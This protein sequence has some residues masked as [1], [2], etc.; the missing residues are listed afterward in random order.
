VFFI[1]GKQTTLK[2]VQE[3]VKSFSIQ[4]DNLCQFLPQDK[5]C[6]F[7]ALS[8]V[9]LLNSTQR[10]AAP[11]E[12]LEWHDGLKLLRTKQKGIQMQQTA[13]KEALENLNRRQELLKADVERLKERAD[14]QERVKM[15]ELARTFNRYGRIRSEFLES[16]Q[17]RKDAQTAL[18]QLEKDLEPSLRAVNQK[19]EYR[20]VI[21]VVVRER[22][23]A[24][25]K[26]Q[27]SADGHIEKF[28][29]LRDRIKQNEESVRAE[30][31]S[32]QKRKENVTTVQRSI[33]VLKHKLKEPAPECDT[34][35]WNEKLVST[36]YAIA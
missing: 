26:A 25:E 30:I 35:K 20:E 14:I 28:N 32:D 15:L 13:D 6:E 7:A 2:A 18:K 19:Q 16:K 22:K 23:T 36:L 24:L 3:L 9:E 8:P 4:I 29:N 11:P 1:D 5:V 34:G 31:T 33:N 12:M 27:A 17:K 10:A 21:Q